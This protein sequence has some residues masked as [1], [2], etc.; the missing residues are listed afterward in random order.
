M[1]EVFLAAFWWCRRLVCGLVDVNT[2]G[3]SKRL[4][5]GWSST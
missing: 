4:A 2:H 5:H 1:A 3:T